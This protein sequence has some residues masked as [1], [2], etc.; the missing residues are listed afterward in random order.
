MD[1]EFTTL[2]KKKINEKSKIQI[3][4]LKDSNWKYGINNQIN[5]FNL[6]INHQDLH[7]LMIINKKICGYT[8]LRKKKYKYSQNIYLLFDTFIIDKNYR[9]FG[10]GKRLMEYNNKVIKENKIKSLL[11]CNI[12][13]VDFYKKFGWEYFDKLDRVKNIKNKI[14]LS[15]DRF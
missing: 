11:Y 14:I 7:N 10:L 6:N 3:C 1:I 13:L 12:N 5:W 8:C 2:T 9:N 15:Y 4:K